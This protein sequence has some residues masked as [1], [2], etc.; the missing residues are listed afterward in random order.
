M[1]G[2]SN[3]NVPYRW[4]LPVLAFMAVVPLLAVQGC[5]SCQS[6]DK[7]DIT[8]YEC[9]P[10][11]VMPGTLVVVNARWDNLSMTDPFTDRDEIALSWEAY[12]GTSNKVAFDTRS[13]NGTEPGRQETFSFTPQDEGIHSLELEALWDGQWKDRAQCDVVVTNQPITDA[14]ITPP[15]PDS[16]TDSPSPMELP[17]AGPPS[18][19][20]AGFWDF[21]T[22]V[23][24]ATG[25]CEGEVEPA[26]LT[27]VIQIVHD[28]GTGEVDASGFNGVASNILRGSLVGSVLTVSGDWPEDNG[29]TTSTYVLNVTSPTQ[30]SGTENWNWTQGNLDCAGSQSTVEAWKRP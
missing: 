6:R 11:V 22:Q 10:S 30:M 4:F 28:T 7:L 21:V 14:G 2:S 25:A 16:F 3:R 27:H 20:L 19:N 8:H 18:L 23:V 24:V 29:T 13:Y 9:V 17:D 26:P 5:Q 12:D 1:S 15:L